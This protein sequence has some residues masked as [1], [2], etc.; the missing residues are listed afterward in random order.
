MIKINTVDRQQ[1]IFNP[2]NTNHLLFKVENQITG[3]Q[4]L[5]EILPENTQR[6]KARTVR[7]Q[8]MKAIMKLIKQRK[9]NLE[10]VMREPDAPQSKYNAVLELGTEFLG[11]SSLENQNLYPALRFIKQR[12]IYRLDY[13]APSYQSKFYK[14]YHMRVTMI[15]AFVN[16]Q[17]RAY[18]RAEQMTKSKQLV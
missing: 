10:S 6:W 7:M 5:E 17:I 16:Q 1:D 2:V 4:L 8:L 3:E 11:L 15:S 9:C 18:E 14:K 13:I 12:L